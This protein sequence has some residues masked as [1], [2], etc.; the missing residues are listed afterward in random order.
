MSKPDW[1]KWPA[2]VT[3]FVGFGAWAAWVNQ[4]HPQVWRFA[5]LQGLYAFVSTLG[6]RHLTLQLR[7]KLAHLAAP[8]L[9]SGFAAAS[10][11]FLLPMT[12][13]TL[14]ANPARLASIAPGFVMSVNYIVL[15]LWNKQRT[16]A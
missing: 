12:L 11:A 3:A 10:F 4:Y 7:E 1:F 2:A 5:M 9:L 15:L 13:Q 8:N 14:A 6:L 16:N